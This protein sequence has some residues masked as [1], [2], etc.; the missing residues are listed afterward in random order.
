MKIEEIKFGSITIDGKKYHQV[1]I[2]GGKIIERESEKLHE[3]FGTSHRVGDW[4]IVTLTQSSPE[5]IIIGQG[6]QGML[7][8]SPETKEKLE[9]SGAKIT[10]LPSL[11]PLR[12]ITNLP[13]KV[14]KSTP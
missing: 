12:N 11:P 7:K 1:L 2:S 5:Y 8:V 13:R 6:F 3:L 9:K 10:A 4:E 14:K